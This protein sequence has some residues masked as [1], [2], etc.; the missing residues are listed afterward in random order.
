MPTTTTPP[1][2]QHMVALRKGD[3]IRLARAATKSQITA[4][5][6]S[7]LEAIDRPEIQSMCIVDL[8]RT[9]HGWGRRRAEKAL[10]MLGAST[11]R[12][13]DELTP[14]QRTVLNEIARRMPARPVPAGTTRS[15]A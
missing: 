9:Q 14:R 1:V 12:R 15:A 4:G 2:P 6:L 10:S 11:T 3:Q 7:L 8:L 13:V 5:E